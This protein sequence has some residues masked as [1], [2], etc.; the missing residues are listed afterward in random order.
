MKSKI[1]PHQG[2][3]LIELLLG[4]AIT[5]IIGVCVYNMFWS[6]MRLDDK[7]RHVHDNY[8]E[9]LMADQG[10]THDLENAVNLDFSASYP[11]SV[12]FDGQ[13]TGF[14]FLTQT[15]AGIKRV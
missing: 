6:A 12:I 11:D 1:K 4:L 14:S 3:T 7:M 8:M 10:L 15:P 13:K 9:I 2:F 5:A